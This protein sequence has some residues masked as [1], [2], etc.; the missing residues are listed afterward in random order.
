[1]LAGTDLDLT[2]II[3]VLITTLPAII[4]AIYARSVRRDVS[5]P[6]GDTIGSVVERTHELT[7]VNTG[8]LQQV[9]E[10]TV[11]GEHAPGGRRE[12]DL[13]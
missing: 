5:T 6:S 11:N 10:K 13:G 12:G 8:M 3:I 1:M 7:A 2:Q 9:H 4:A